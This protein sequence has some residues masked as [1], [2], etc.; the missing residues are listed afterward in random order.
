MAS[1]T[2]EELVTSPGAKTVA[3][4][5]GGAALGF[6]VGGPVGA[7]V[8]GLA[9]AGAVG[10]AEASKEA[11]RR[12]R[13]AIEDLKNLETTVKQETSQ[14]TKGGTESV[15]KTEFTGRS[16]QEE[17]L[18]TKSIRNFERQHNLAA[19]QEAALGGRE[20]LEGQAQAGL[21]GILGGQAFAVSPEEQ[22]RIDAL[23]SS[24][25]D[26]GQERVNRFLQQNL[27][28]IEADAAARGVRGQ[29][30]S[31]LQTGALESASQALQQ[32]TLEANRLAAEQ[33][34]Q[35]PGQRVGIQAQTAG[36]FADFAGMSRERAIQN[37]QL[38]QD[39]I[40]LQQLR[41]ERL[42]GGTT[43]QGTTTDQTVTG[44]DLRT[45]RGEGAA[46]AI[47]ALG[48]SPGA[49]ASGLGGL[50][51]GLGAG[52]KIAGAA[53]GGGGGAAALTGGPVPA[54]AR[55]SSGPPAGFTG[56]ADPS[57]QTSPTGTIATRPAS[58]TLR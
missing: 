46:A 52:A 58:T 26:V 57:L 4:A 28:G 48:Q 1:S 8:G 25:L 54:A 3:G 33:A 55:S 39:P 5:A 21:G 18:L 7:V 19:Q 36:Q 22:A 49:T 50:F 14:T 44:E 34:L 32:Q 17:A 43:T 56:G 11:D 29:A 15:Q 10:G 37:R 24:T 47:A 13:E 35:L 42:R 41:D 40:A 51:E 30:F 53:G 31:Q 16:P 12:Q 6:A 38:L 27:A 45:G 9:G 2:A 20:Q 23:R